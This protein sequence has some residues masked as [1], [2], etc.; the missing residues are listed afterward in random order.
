MKIIELSG[1]LGKGKF[2]LVDDED[3]EVCST[4]SWHL[5]HR[6]RAKANHKLGDKWKTVFIHRFLLNFPNSPIDHIN[7]DPLDNR[8]SNLRTCTSAQNQANRPPRNG[9][10]FKGTLKDG[11]KWRA[12]MKANG[13]DISLGSFDTE[14]EAA[15]AYNKAAKK[16]FGEF[17]WL[18]KV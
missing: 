15:K 10:K 3:F 5:T 8:R 2:L 18:N 4:K 9:R 13:K 6:G 16:Y 12:R 7:G 1:K 17:A 11:K 14:L